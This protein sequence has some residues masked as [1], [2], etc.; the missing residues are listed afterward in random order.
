MSTSI[1]FITSNKGKP[2]LVYDGYLYK[3]NKATEKVKYWTC[4]ERTC[5]ASVH[6]DSDDQFIKSKGNHGSHLPS[7]E[8]IEWRMFKSVVKKRI[9][10]ESIAIGLIY[11]QELARAN[12]SQAG[13]AVSLSSQ[14]AKSSLNKLRRKTTPILPDSSDFDI[15]DLYSTTI[16][17]RRFLLGDLAYHRKRILIF[18]TDEQLTVLFKAKQIML[19]GTFEACPPYFEQVYTLHC[20]KHGKSFPC[21]IALLDGRSTNIYKQLFTE[22][23]NHATRL[24]LDFDPTAILSDFEK[25]LLKAFPQ[26]T[27]H[28]CYFHFCQAV[29]RKIQNLGLATYYRDDEHIRDTCRQLMS[30]A[31]LPCRE[32]EFAFEEIVSKA[33]PLLLNLIDYFRNFW[34][35]Q[36]PVKIWNVHNLDIRT[37]N[38]AEGWHNRFNRRINKTHPN[39][40]HFISTL[41]QEEVYFRQQILHMKSG[42]NK[43]RSKKVCA[44]QDRLNALSSRFDNQEIDVQEYLHGLSFF[45]AKNVKN[46][47]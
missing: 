35:R 10:E 16:D 42:K 36:M 21:V 46:K 34:F 25:A 43:N 20:I 8:E 11:D 6:T 27:H 9:K 5:S 19:D 13:L 32:V 14:E 12:F 2:L 24:Q 38:N 28:A 7:P 41:K 44:M 47:N 26:A 30:L 37:N 3:L 17:S 18:S 4:Q 31:L 15:P 1:Y 22:L 29:Y 39:I 33:P 45:V 40:W 23:E